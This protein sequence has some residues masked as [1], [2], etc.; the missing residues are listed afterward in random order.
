V[1]PYSVD[2]PD[3]TTLGEEPEVELALVWRLRAREL[4]TGLRAKEKR[5]NRV[6]KVPRRFTEALFPLSRN[7]LR[8]E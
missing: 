2:H 4:L 1:N 3:S 8:N 5:R 7:A 6:L